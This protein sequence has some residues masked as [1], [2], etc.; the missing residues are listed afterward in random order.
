MIQHIRKQKAKAPKEKH[1]ITGTQKRIIV[2][3]E[4]I[5]RGNLIL[6]NQEYPIVEEPIPEDLEAPFVTQPQHLLVREAADQL[7]KLLEAVN[8]GNQ[9]V[10]VSGYRSLEQQQKIWQDSELEHGLEYTQTY[11]AIPNHSEHQTGLAIDVAWNQP[12][13]DFIC[14]EF[15]YEGICQEFRRM[16]ANYGFVERYP[17]GWE[18]VTGIG[19]EPWHFRYVG[20]PHAAFMQE[21]AM[22]LEEYTEWIR[23]F[24][25]ETNPYRNKGNRGELIIG[26]V[27]CK[28]RICEITLPGEY[29]YYI[30]GNNVDG[31]VLTAWKPFS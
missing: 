16:A 9:I 14:P 7:Q 15:P 11:V 4:D 3:E 10:G 30:S 6:V 28:Q 29:Q 12:D 25:L 27:L 17:A 31:V 21:Q 5:F 18:T 19:A 23:G 8:A 22:V 13:I 24:S 1:T 26:H 2:K 20:V